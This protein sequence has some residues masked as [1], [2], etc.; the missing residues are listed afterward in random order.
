MEVDRNLADQI[1]RAIEDRIR[2]ST[3]LDQGGFDFVQLPNGANRDFLAQVWGELEGIFLAQRIRV[4]IEDFA[5]I[6]QDGDGLILKM[7]RVR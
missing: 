3:N 6:P 7:R 2:K 1:K 4:E 5:P